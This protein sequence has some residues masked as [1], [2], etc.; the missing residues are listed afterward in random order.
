MMARTGKH[1]FMAHNS[2]F[3]PFRFGGRRFNIVKSMLFVKDA[4]NP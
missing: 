2:A 3:P 4:K 1:G